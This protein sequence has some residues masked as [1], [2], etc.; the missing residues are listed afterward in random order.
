MLV[1]CL[2][3]A[4]LGAVTPNFRTVHLSVHHG[5]P[6]M[7]RLDFV[8]AEESAEDREEIDYIVFEFEA[9]QCGPLMAEVVVTVDSY[10]FERINP[11]GRMVYA[12]KERWPAR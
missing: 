8:L 10:P 6:A 4:M 9:M 5:K 1:L 3:Q 2:V 7:V 12:R 11:G